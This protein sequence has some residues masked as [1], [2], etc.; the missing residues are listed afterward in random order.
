MGELPTLLLLLDASNIHDDERTRRD[1][2]A[3]GA[4]FHMRLFV[5]YTIMIVKARAS[6]LPLW[7]NTFWWDKKQ[8]VID[9][10]S[11]PKAPTSVCRLLSSA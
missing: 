10:P 11:V 9:A 1:K 8:L 4:E 5:F 7:L 3:M 2:E 6:L